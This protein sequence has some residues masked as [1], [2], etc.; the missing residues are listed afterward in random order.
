MEL[1][2]FGRPK[3]VIDNHPSLP[4]LNDFVD[5]T[6]SAQLLSGVAAHIE[7]CLVCREVVADLRDLI[8]IARAEGQQLVRAPAALQSLVAAVTIHC[9]P[10]WRHFLRGNRGK[11]VF[12]ALA[13]MLAGASAGVWLVLG[14]DNDKPGP[15]TR[16]C[17]AP[18]YRVV[19][20]GMQERVKELRDYTK[21]NVNVER[22]RL[23]HSLPR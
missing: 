18:W 21:G 6:L 22:K 12:A 1:L 5:G 2:A 16:E 17:H 23:Q 13:L 7:G 19:R 10:L 8:A 20:Y 4:A 3:R 14:C 9:R 15:Q 11:L